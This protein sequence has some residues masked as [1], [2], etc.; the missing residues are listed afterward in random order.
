MGETRGQ[1]NYDGYRDR[2]GSVQLPPWD[3]LDPTIQA[4]FEEGAARVEAQFAE[5]FR[6]LFEALWTAAKPVVIAGAAAV[7]NITRE[8]E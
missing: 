7:R 2:D 1:V 8:R 5:Q 3:E 6:T 4:A